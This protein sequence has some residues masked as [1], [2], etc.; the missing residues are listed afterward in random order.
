LWVYTNLHILISK[1]IKVYLNFFLD[2]L[3]FG[4]NIDAHLDHLVILIKMM[5]KIHITVAIHRRNNEDI[6]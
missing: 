3:F 2:A 1:G 4:N 5:V 6:P